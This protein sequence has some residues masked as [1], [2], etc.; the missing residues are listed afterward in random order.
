MPAPP[1]GR[2]DV[3]ILSQGT[4]TGG[5]GR[6]SR[7]GHRRLPAISSGF[8]NGKAHR[9]GLGP[10]E[11][12][13]AHSFTASEGYQR[14]TR[15]HRKFKRA[16]LAPLQGASLY[17]IYRW[18]RKKRSTTGYKLRS[19]RDQTGLVVPIGPA[20]DRP[21]RRT[22]ELAEIYLLPQNG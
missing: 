19:L 18:C 3:G 21:C 7:K 10:G 5:G 9:R 22:L 17:R 6:G 20:C 4:G 8:R 16:T 2:W 15:S 11:N 12:G 1:H 13:L 14:N